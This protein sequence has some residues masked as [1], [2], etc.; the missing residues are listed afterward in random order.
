MKILALD[1]GG[2][3]LKCCLVSPEGQVENLN[4]YA[5]GENAGSREVI[6]IIC[7]ALDTYED[8]AGVA[9]STTG[10]PDANGV[11]VYASDNIPGYRGTR[12]K[13]LIEVH[14][15]KSACVLR[16][17]FA[18]AWGEKAYGAG[19]KY[20]DFVCLTYGSG[21]GG[22]MVINGVPYTGYSLSAGQLGHM[23]THADG[24]LCQCGKKGCYE[25]YASAK[26]LEERAQDITGRKMS[27]YEIVEGYLRGDADLCRCLTEWMNEVIY[28][29]VSIV[30]LL[31]PTCVVLGGGIMEQKNIVEFIRE[32]VYNKMIDASRNFDIVQAHSGNTINLLGCAYCA[33]IT[34]GW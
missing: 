16:D 27:G 19:L 29:I 31:N 21:V 8:Y 13:E 12:L 15:G 2:T 28:G 24:K 32:N 23:I 11:I 7:N 14:T 34:W 9:V 17:A 25:A 5:Y 30:H 20:Q 3:S 1:V 6:D 18:M 22:A 4:K 26:A 33:K 10:Q